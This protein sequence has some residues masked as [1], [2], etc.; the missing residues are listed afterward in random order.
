MSILLSSRVPAPANIYNVR[1]SVACIQ[2]TALPVELVSFT[3]ARKNGGVELAWKTATEVNNAG[4]EIEKAVVSSQSSEKTWTKVGYIEG[5]GTSNVPQVYSYND[6]SANP[7]G[8]GGTV[9]YRLKQIDRDGQFEYSTTVDA[10]VGMTSEDYTLAQN[11]PNPFNPNTTIT[12]TMKSAE[13]VNVLVYNSLGQEVATLF[14][15][16][17]NPNQIYRLNFDGKN[18]T[19]GTYFY[20][21]RSA[22]RNEVRKM[23]LMK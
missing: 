20:A 3:A 9:F 1:T 6:A 12:F 21:L 10:T 17:A 16:I 19:S 2:Q 8:A 5:H 15:G 23:L 18:L 11:F 4:F 13:H 7:K 14:N 22:T